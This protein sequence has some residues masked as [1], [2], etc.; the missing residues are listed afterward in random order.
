MSTIAPAH[1]VCAAP[2]RLTPAAGRGRAQ[3]A[4]DLRA[5][6]VP[7]RALNMRVSQIWR[8]LYVR[9]LTG[10]EP[11]TTI[12][13]EMRGALAARDALSSG[14]DGLRRPCR[15]FFLAAFADIPPGVI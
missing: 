14:R 3:L 8:G 13:K 6:G 7:E 10:F 9:G 11:L 12:S 5:M 15:S 4:G 2:A 1:D